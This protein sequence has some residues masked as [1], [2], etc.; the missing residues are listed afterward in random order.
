MI[1][2]SKELRFVIYVASGIGSL[3][4]T[5]LS[6]KGLIGEPEITFWA[7]LTTLVGGLAAVN[8]K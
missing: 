5:Y 6:S 4:V 3:L 7:G 1:I 2:K 8:T